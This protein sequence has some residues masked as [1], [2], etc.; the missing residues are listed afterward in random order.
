MVD[1]LGWRR[2]FGVIAP[3]TNTVVQPE[4]DDMRP[5]G[6]TNHIARMHIPDDPV[7]SDAELAE[8]VR[9]IDTLEEALDRVMTC[10]PDHVI[11]GVSAESFWGGGLEPSRRIAARVKARAGGISL[12]QAA[13]AI[14]AAL[15]AYGVKERLAVVTP[16]RPSAEPYIREYVEAIGY[17]LVAARHLCCESPTL[18]AH[19]SEAELRAALSAVDG[20]EVEALVQFGTNLPALRLAAEAERWLGKPVIA[21]NAATYWHALRKNGIADRKPGLGRLLAEF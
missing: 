5:P 21:I 18:I 2:K 13:E 7:K 20:A 8:L 3:S 19:V 11:L 1:Q 16:Y 14:P 17:R 6:V 4:Y 12:T 10:K 9:R 15:K